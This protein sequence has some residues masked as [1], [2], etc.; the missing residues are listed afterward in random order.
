MGA[1]CG[2]VDSRV[3]KF[4]KRPACA[5]VDIGTRLALE[6]YGLTLDTTNVDAPGQT[7]SCRGTLP[8][9]FR[10]ES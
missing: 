6:R 1:V 3:E 2:K 4:E 7:V 8:S 9:T 10:K 5:L